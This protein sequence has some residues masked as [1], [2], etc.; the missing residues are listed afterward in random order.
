MPER[1]E[2][3]VIADRAVNSVMTICGNVGWACEVVHKD[4]GDDLVA[5]TTL[6]EQVDPFRIWIQV[7]GTHDIALFRNKSGSYSINVSFDHALKWI[8]ST[9]PVVVVLWDVTDDFGLFT[10]P[11]DSMDQW[12][13]YLEPDKQNKLNFASTAVF[14]E[15]EATKISWRARINHYATL[16]ASA[17]QLDEWHLEMSDL[18]P[19]A[20]QKHHS[21][22][23]LLAFDLLKRIGVLDNHFIDPEFLDYYENAMTNISRKEPTTAEEERI[24]LAAAGLRPHFCLWLPTHN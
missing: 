22:V 17:I 4:Y 16:M 18:G 21:Q 15:A 10:I 13:L 2:S 1:P 24:R 11:K 9:D 19:E 3:H 5:Q 8:R 23:P 12:D 14:D 20:A 6:Q 7:K